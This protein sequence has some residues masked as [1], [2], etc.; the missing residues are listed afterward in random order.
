MKNS[1]NGVGA[2]VNEIQ[3]ESVIQGKKLF[4][5]VVNIIIIS[6]WKKCLT[7]VLLQK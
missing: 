3:S 2:D 4:F 5:I 6:W 1:G 7:F